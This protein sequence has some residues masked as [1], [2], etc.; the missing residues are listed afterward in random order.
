M[1]TIPT[2]LWL[3][4]ANAS[5]AFT[6][7]ETR[8][9][10]SFRG[11]ARA[12]V[13]LLGEL[14]ACGYCLGHWTAFVLVAVYRPRLLHAWLPLDYFLTALV[15]AWLGAFQWVTLCWLSAQSGK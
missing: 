8:L 14:V 10:A 3:S 13:P 11:W 15:V 9:F 6:V 1:S 5:I 12:R 2:V 4:A 7:A